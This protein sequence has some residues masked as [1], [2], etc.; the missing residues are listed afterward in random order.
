MFNTIVGYFKINN[1]AGEMT[2]VLEQDLIDLEEQILPAVGGA[3]KTMGKNP[4]NSKNSNV[5]IAKIT[6]ETGWGNKPTDVFNKLEKVIRTITSNKQ[7]LLKLMSSN[8]TNDI[9]DNTITA[10]EAGIITFMDYVHFISIYTLEFVDVL[11]QYEV[12]EYTSK[13][14]SPLYGKAKI[15]EIDSLAATYGKI[16]ALLDK[17]GIKALHDVA[18]LPDLILAMGDGAAKYLTETALTKSMKAQ[19]TDILKLSKGF[20]GNPIYHIGLYRATKEIK[21]HEKRKAYMTVLQLRLLELKN[22][23][24][25]TPDANIESQI[26]YYE[27]KIAKLDY[28]IRQY[29]AKYEED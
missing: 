5:L 13:G 19:K 10:K 7:Q 15:K 14:K 21:K 4:F 27:K 2:T 17:H 18:K 29:E 16:L 8:I 28:S 1:N 24:E 26:D 11:V 6:R 25:K 20:H 23:A 3:V 12:N 9:T 22:I